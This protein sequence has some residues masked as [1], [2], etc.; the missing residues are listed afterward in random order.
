[1]SSPNCI[2]RPKAVRPATGIRASKSAV[3][4]GSPKAPANSGLPLPTGQKTRLVKAR[5]TEFPL[6]PQFSLRELA[7]VGEVGLKL[8]DIACIE[9]ELRFR[10]FHSSKSTNLGFAAAL[11][12]SP[13]EP[14]SFKRHSY[15][16]GE[17]VP[18]RP[19][20]PMNRDELW[21]A[22]GISTGSD[23][24]SD[25]VSVNRKDLDPSEDGTEHV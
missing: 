5:S 20:N 8:A 22:E 3:F 2:A 4:P 21:T 7:G 25:Q 24:D 19:T 11:S 6:P 12:N 1:M 15:P 17:L 13:E 18:A 10:Q 16:A 9:S 14:E 23:S